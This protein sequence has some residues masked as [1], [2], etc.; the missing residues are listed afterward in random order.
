[1]LCTSKLVISLLFVTSK[2]NFPILKSSQLPW[3]PSASWLYM[4]HWSQELF[5]RDQD[6]TEEEAVP[7]T[8][9]NCWLLIHLFRLKGMHLGRLKWHCLLKITISSPPHTKSRSKW[10]MIPKILDRS[11]LLPKLIRSLTKTLCLFIVMMIRSISPMLLQ[12]PTAKDISQSCPMC[13]LW[14]AVPLMSSISNG[15]KA[16]TPLNS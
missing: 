6:L 14:T 12:L 8:K 7:K 10:V 9:M 4:P 2:S 16:K 11:S 13:L 15:S 5:L 1:M 3:T